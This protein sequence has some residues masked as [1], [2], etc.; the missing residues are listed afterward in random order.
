MTIQADHYRAV[1][2]SRAF[3]IDLIE[4]RL[5]LE[6]NRLIYTRVNERLSVQ[7]FRSLILD[8]PKGQAAYA[9]LA[10]RNSYSIGYSSSDSG[11]CGRT[12]GISVRAAFAA[13]CASKSRVAA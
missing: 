5:H 12:A 2:I 7:S 13:W 3:Y 11:S 4:D 8:R 9:Y 10:L 1:Y 6:S